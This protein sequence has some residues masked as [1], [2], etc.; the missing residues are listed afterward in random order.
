[1][2]PPGVRARRIRMNIM[3]PT[4]L[5][6]LLAA[7]VQTAPQTKPVPAA[8]APAPLP[9]E[10]PD[11]SRASPVERLRFEASR[12]LPT[13]KCPDA[14]RFLLSASFLPFPGDRTIW[15]NKAIREALTP[16][17]YEALTKEQRE[18]FV[19]RTVTE[20]EYYYTRY[21]SPLAYT[22]PLS[23]LCETIG[24]EHALRAKRILD[25][26]YG[27]IGH[28]RLLAQ[29]GV[30]CVGVEV[31]P[32]LRALYSQPEDTGTIEGS[33]LYNEQLPPG[34]IR[35]VHGK[36]PG[37]AG[38]AEQVGGEYDI[39]LSKNTLKNGYINPEKPVDKRML[40]DLGVPAKE[41]VSAIASR[42][43]PGGLFLIYNICPAQKP[44]AYIPWA[45]GRC[46]FPREMLEE[47]GLEVVAF[48]VNDDRAVREMARALL[49]DRGEQPMDLDNDLF[50][51]YTLCRKVPP[52]PE[53]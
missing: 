40:V 9:E 44:D 52:T 37:D 5:S 22:R 14:Q 35:L 18:G 38:V 42:L 27:T 51:W 47:A 50:A 29:T 3:L 34:A 46:P 49:W 7:C 10:L 28:L 23:I 43:K 30:F 45:D 8:A 4:V 36:F 11:L 1:M 26:G 20:Q 25:Y 53:K 31:D 48:D 6:L 39:I 21:G 41:F 33:S 19:E 2:F 15:Q 32:V 16:G 12:L 24:G 17:E 13:T